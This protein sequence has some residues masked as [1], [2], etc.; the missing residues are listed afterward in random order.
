MGVVAEQDFARF[1]WLGVGHNRQF[2]AA[3][4]LEVTLH[5]LRCV[6]LRR[7]RVGGDHDAVTALAFFNERRGS[8]PGGTERE[9]Q[10][11]GYQDGQFAHAVLLPLLVRMFLVETG[12]HVGR[13][14]PNQR[15][16][17]RAARE[18]CDEHHG[19]EYNE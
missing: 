5:F 8:Q 11:Y 10:P 19:T 14:R 2:G 3:H 6:M 17:F 7:N 16:R 18:Q 13:R 9:G 15:V 12:E 4:A 1:D